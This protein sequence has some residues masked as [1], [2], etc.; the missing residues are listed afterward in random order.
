MN[1]KFSRFSTNV[2]CASLFL[3]LAWFVA[4]QSA[5]AQ[6]EGEPIVV[7]EVIA[8]VNNDIVTL[9]MVK[10]EMKE[11]VD[12]LKNNRVPEREAETKVNAAQNEIIVGLINEQLLVQ[13]GKDLNLTNDVEADVNKRLL[14]I[15]KEQGI[16]TI[17]KLDAALTASGIN[18]AEFRQTMRTELM[19]GMVFNAEVD[20]RVF[21][22][23]SAEEAKKYFETHPDKFRRQ[24]SVELSEI[25]LSLAG[26]PEAD[27]R[28]RA[29]QI[30]TQARAAGAD[31]AALAVAN[32]ERE[33]EGARVAPQTKGKLGRVEV[34]GISR[35]EVLAALKDLKAGGVTEPI[36]LEEGLLILRVDAREAAGDAT[37]NETRARELMTVERGEKE[38]Q[39]YLQSLRDDAFIKIAK[40]YEAA[41]TP[42]LNKKPA[43]A[44]AAG[45]TGKEANKETSK[46]GEQKTQPAETKAARP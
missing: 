23:I 17:E 7:E 30:V 31:F 16:D 27:V 38:R 10:R 13:K 4:P 22:G 19:K 8:Q 11:A 2:W 41:L 6:E 42:L 35:P 26:K 33:V 37:F 39:T 18:P 34:S 24:E 15:A 46:S 14:E 28:A 32:S 45:E 29:A 9:S 36:K 3:T 21:F 1:L 12:Q 20:R 44:A 43:A 5:R 25:F 40:D